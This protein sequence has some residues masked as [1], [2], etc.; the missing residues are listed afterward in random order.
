MAAKE[1]DRKPAETHLEPECNSRKQPDD[2]GFTQSGG[3]GG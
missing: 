1:S 3:T 2:P